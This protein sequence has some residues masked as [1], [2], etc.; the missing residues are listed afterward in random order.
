MSFDEGPELCHHRHERDTQVLSPPQDKT[1][2]AAMQT[3][4]P[5]PL[6]SPVNCPPVS[7]PVMLAFLERHRNGT[8]RPA[9]F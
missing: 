4:P 5:V 7:A 2:P 9:A 8:I 6:L 3:D 1:H